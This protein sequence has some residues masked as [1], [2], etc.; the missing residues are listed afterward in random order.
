[1]AKLKIGFEVED[2]WDYQLFRDIIKKLI[3]TSDYNVYL[4]TKTIDQDLINSV[5]TEVGLNTDNIVQVVDNNELLFKLDF[6]GVDIYLTPDQEIKSLIDTNSSL[7][8][9][10]G[11]IGIQVNSSIP[12]PNKLQP[13]WV[14]QLL[15]WI[16]RL[17]EVEKEE[18]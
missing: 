3:E 12:D 15:F 7:P 17:S 11:T 16:D 8:D 9:T 13:K 14:T 2:N 4:I 5:V 1:M 6:I 10:Y 18:C